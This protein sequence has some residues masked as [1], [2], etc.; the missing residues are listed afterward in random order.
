MTEYLVV[1]HVESGPPPI[2]LFRSESEAAQ[3]TFYRM[4]LRG[5]DEGRYSEDV[6]GI[7]MQSVA[8]EPADPD[9]DQ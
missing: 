7:E 4:A 8:P 6:I 1:A 5:I 3:R 9:D 2:V